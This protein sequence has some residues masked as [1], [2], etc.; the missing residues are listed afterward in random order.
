MFH[1]GKWASI[2]QIMAGTVFPELVQWVDLRRVLCT[3][4][5]P[6]RVSSPFVCK[7]YIT[8]SCLFS[9]VLEQ[10]YYALYTVNLSGLFVR[11]LYNIEDGMKLQG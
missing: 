11:V 4:L 7:D 5:N 2:H 9:T 6:A 1:I 3:I 10:T 8:Y